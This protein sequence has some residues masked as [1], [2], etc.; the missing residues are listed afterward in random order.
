MGEKIHPNTY[1]TYLR[2]L[3][4]LYFLFIF[5][6]VAQLVQKLSPINILPD[7]NSWHSAT[8]DYSWLLFFQLL[9]IL[10][11]SVVIQKFSQGN[12]LPNRKTAKYLLIVGAVYFAA[13]AFRLI[14]GLSFAKDHYWFGALLP[15]IF[16]LVLASF[17]LTLAKFHFE[18]G[19]KNSE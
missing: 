5:R 4:T 9:I 2:L 17:L 15:T 3:L 1:K 10:V 8:L 11:M 16:H 19:E 6:V 18:T 12:I 13:M 7:F 14:A